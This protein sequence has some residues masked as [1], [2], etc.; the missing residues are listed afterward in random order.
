[1]VCW[2]VNGLT[3]KLGE[4]GFVDYIKSFDICCLLETFTTVNFDFSTYFDEYKI[5]HSPARKLSH[6]GRR[7]GGVIVMIKACIESLVSEIQVNYD[8]IIAF[9]IS[10]FTFG[11]VI[12][13]CVYVPPIDSPYYKERDIT[14][15]IIVLED[16]LLQ[17][18]E[19]FPDSEILICGDMNARIGGWDIHTVNEHYDDEDDPSVETVCKCPILGLD[20]TSQ[21][22]S[23][24]VFG[25]MLKTLCSIHHLFILNGCTTGDRDGRYT[26]ISPHGESVIDYCLLAA[27]HPNHTINL[28]V[29]SRVESDH[30][31][32]EITVDDETHTMN[33]VISETKCISNVRWDP[34]KANYFLENIQGSAFTE[35]LHQAFI[36]I[37]TS[38]ESA[39]EL[40]NQCIM[41]SAECMRKFLIV[42]DPVEKRTRSAWFDYD[43]RVAKQEAR[44]AL[45]RYRYTKHATDKEPFLTCRKRYKSLI[46]EKKRTFFTST[47]EALVKSR[48]D[49]RKFWLMIRQAT[50]KSPSQ[51]QINI[52]TWKEHFENLFHQGSNIGIPI[53]GVEIPEKE[54]IRRDPELDAPIATFEVKAAIKKIKPGKSPGLDEIPGECFKAAADIVVPFLTKLFNALFESQYF[55]KV[56]SRSVIIP[57]HKRG[58]KLNPTNYRGI[59]LLSILSKVFSSVLTKRLYRWAEKN[60]RICVE[61]A[62]F[63]TRYSTIDHIFTLH[64]MVLKHVYGEGR[65]KLYVAFVDYAKAFDSVNRQQLWKVLESSGLSTKF[66]RMLKAMYSEVKACVR[67]DHV[68]SEFFNCPFGVKQGALE[69]STIFSLYINVVADYV[70]QFGKHGIQLLPG[71]A[72]L[73][74]LLFAD[75]IIL[76]STTPVGL[77]NQLNNLILV[78]TTLG[79]CANTDKTKV[80]VFRRGGHLSFGEQWYLG[81][82]RLEVVNRYKYLGYLF[83]TKLSLK[84]LLDDIATKGKQK[85]VQILKT[86]WS[87]HNMS[88]DVFFKLFD[89]QV[90]PTILYTSEIWGL[91]NTDGIE[92]THVFACKRF[93]GLDIRTPNHLVHGELG[94]YPLSIN[95]SIRVIKYWLKLSKMPCTRIPKQA[96]IML[97]NSRIPDLINWSGLVKDFLC[98][99]G[100]A[101]V[102]LNGG[103]GNGKAFIRHLKQRLQDIYQQTW[104]ANNCS[105]DRY[106]WYSSFKSTFGLE[107]YLNRLTIKKFRDVFIR[108]RFGINDLKVNRR[109]INSL[110]R[111][112]K[113]PFCN[114]RESEEHF[115]LHC[116]LYRELRDKYIKRH[117]II[118]KGCTYLLQLSDNQKSRDVA[119]YVYY[120]LQIREQMFLQVDT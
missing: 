41:S 23:V 78:S 92:K 84:V 108:F 42:S 119:M 95:S 36:T 79:L 90:Q 49:P 53:P 115:L 18:Q 86:M 111:D 77:Q 114:D 65:G 15:N 91:R 32:L 33:N 4:P 60:G 70:R 47:S 55:P 109:F 8:N 22:S 63:R 40:F 20:R 46:R 110:T 106:L 44:R 71:T 54:I 7:S 12:V 14:C 73:F 102:W 13:V 103:V 56:W 38:V 35:T 100:F 25:E 11:N 10:N 98:R 34:E 116:P 21:D 105:S 24:N 67:W 112:T 104:H 99:C 69:S 9:K 39:L 48:K 74:F 62:G 120:A 17:V 43:C 5:L 26:Y 64:A 68:T 66:I 2:N 93:L 30:L 87:L 59:S 52:Q 72:E 80:M 16:V 28:V 88:T 118:S 107:S 85:V 61:Q 117:Y 83:T 82:R 76:L 31:P 27:E 113:C 97:L 29:A 58:S 101:Y 45:N 57:L 1:M 37:D 96:Y 50:R 89:A 19:T 51:P 81:N 6:H 94:R 3:S 75:D